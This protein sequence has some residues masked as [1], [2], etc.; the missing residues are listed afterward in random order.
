[1]IGENVEVRMPELD[2]FI[3]TKFVLDKWYITVGDSVK[4]GDVIIE[5]ESDKAKFE[6]TAENEGI[7]VHVAKNTKESIQFNDLL[8]VI[9]EKEVEKSTAKPVERSDF[10]IESS[11]SVGAELILMPKMGKKMTK[12]KISHWNLEVGDYINNDDILAEVETDKATMELIPYCTGTLLYTGAK[13][14]SYIPVDGII[15]VIGEKESEY[16]TLVENYNQT[17][18]N[19]N[20]DNSSFEENKQNKKSGFLNR[21]WDF[22]T[23]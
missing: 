22:L 20:S 7:I 13:K 14:G 2:E 10:I 11:N 9:G 5:V 1:M 6:L 19:N 21:L 23:P 18:K 17:I 15:A 4:V 16:R 12:G 8:C 3:G